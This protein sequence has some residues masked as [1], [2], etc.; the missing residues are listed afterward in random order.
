MR[1]Q[2]IESTT[3][4]K[5]VVLVGCGNIGSHL[6]PHLARLP[7]IARITCIDLDVYE[8]K[9][10]LCQDITPQDVGRSKAGVQARRLR[11]INPELTVHPIK[12]PVQNIPLGQLRADLILS[13][14]DS[15]EARRY[16]HQV[17]WRLG[18]PFIDAGIAADDFLAR[19]NVYLPGA[20]TACMECSW[21]E[22]DYAAL[23][24]TYPCQLGEKSNTSTP[25]STNAPSSLGALAA[26]LQAIEAGK[27]LANRIEYA[28]VGREIVVNA[29][30]HRHF[31]TETRRRSDCRF[32]HEVWKFE[33][34]GLHPKAITVGDALE[35]GTELLA[36]GESARLGVEGTAFV[37][38]LSCLNCG[39]TRNLLRLQNRLTPRERTCTCGGSMIAAAFDR[40]EYI[41]EKR[42]G[43]KALGRSLASIGFRAG[44]IF[45]VAS[46][47]GQAHYELGN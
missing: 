14:L 35:L 36:P 46:P 5:T 25:F 13:C 4:G 23:E 15:K 6:A 3:I 1:Q 43:H 16:T 37:A 41:D 27:I 21:S 47:T 24:Q 45:T 28:A 26:S 20:H 34:L 22:E 9:N 18:V 7:G 33:E 12:D 42:L 30:S 19:A 32:D 2:T 10:L 31:V 8:Q 11:R 29:L 17:A 39:K 44:D 40:S 38:K